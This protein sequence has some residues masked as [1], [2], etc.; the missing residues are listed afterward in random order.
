MDEEVPSFLDCFSGGRGD[1]SGEVEGGFGGTDIEQLDEKGGVAQSF[2]CEFLRLIEPEVEEE[3]GMEDYNSVPLLGIGG[4]VCLSMRPQ[5]MR[6]WRRI[7]PIFS[8]N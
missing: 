5:T 8:A 6:P 3:E 7:Y 4:I 2:N 1:L